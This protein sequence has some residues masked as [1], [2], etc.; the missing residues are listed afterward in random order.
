MVLTEPR[1]CFLLVSERDTREAKGSYF[2]QIAYNLLKV[3][4]GKFT[5][6]IKTN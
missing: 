1:L 4:V 5:P 6:K 2:P 3:E